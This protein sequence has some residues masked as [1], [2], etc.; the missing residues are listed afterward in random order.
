MS[1]ATAQTL[2]TIQRF[3]IE[4]P[5]ADLDD[6]R[7]RLART[8]W[9]SQLPEV[10]WSRGVPLD[11]VRELAEY[12]RTSY[13]WREHEA[14]L[15]ELPQFVTDVD[16][17]NVHFLHI[18]S[19]EPDALPLIMTHGWPGSIVEFLDV[20]GPLTDPRAH[21]GDP[22]DAFHLVIPSIPGFGLSGPTS[23]PG[24]S[25]GRVGRAF[26]ELMSRLGYER[27]GAQGGDEGAIVSPDVGRAA[28]DHVVGVHVNAASIG[29]MPFPPLEESELAVLSDAERDRAARIA[30]YVDEGSGYAAIQSTRPQTLAYGLN[31]SPVGQLAWIVDKFQAWTYG[32]GLPDD[33]VGRDRLL[34]NVMLYW[35]TGTGGSSANSY[36]E[37]KHSGA[38]P[39]PSGVPTG[40]AVFAEDISIRRYAEQ[41]NN[42]VH[43][44]DFDRGG[45]FAAMETPDLLIADVRT[46]FRPLR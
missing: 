44:S 11:Y 32:S 19:A 34:T 31:D 15:N 38:W 12:W 28:P 6:L 25:A 24:W 29:F 10:G 16:G 3:K 39:M 8:R 43:W 42:I 45:H 4:I 13:D 7:D 27:Y 30:E 2:E 5:D 41:S 1:H 22:A 23:E 26:A 35:L 36:Y 37:D 17:A 20:I 21:G 14:R 18:R 40:V 9:P 46:F 33:A